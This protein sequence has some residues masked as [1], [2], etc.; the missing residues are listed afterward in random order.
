LLKRVRK[1]LG[2]DREAP[3]A[4][5]PAPAS[6]AI[7]DKEALYAAAY[8]AASEQDDEEVILLGVAA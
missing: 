5:A 2:L 6:Y 3:P 1:S 7:E 8:K 4:V